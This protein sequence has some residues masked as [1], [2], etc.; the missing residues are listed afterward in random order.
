MSVKYRALLTTSLILL[1]MVVSIYLIARMV[2]LNRFAEIEA[3]TQ[4]ENLSQ[5]DKAI[6]RIYSDIDKLALDWAHWDDLHLY[7]LGQKPDFVKTNINP[8]IY[9]DLSVELIAFANQNGDIL[10]SEIYN[11]EERISHPGPPDLEPLMAKGGL[12]WGL[13]NKPGSRNRLVVTSRGTFMIN[14]QA[15][16]PTDGAPPSSGTLIFGKLVD[17]DM[18]ALL[19]METGLQINFFFPNSAPSSYQAIRPQINSAQSMYFQEDPNSDTFTGFVVLEGIDGQVAGVFQSIVQRTIY[20][21]GRL[22]LNYLLLGMIC[23]AVIGLGV[24]WLVS[25]FYIFRPMERLARRVQGSTDLK[26]Q[27]RSLSEQENSVLTEISMPLQNVLIRAQQ[28]QQESSDRQVL[29]ARLFEQAREAF[30]ILDPDSLI[31]LECNQEFASLLDCVDVLDLPQVSFRE[32]ITQH[33]S[34]NS[35]AIFEHWLDKALLEDGG[36]VEVEFERGNERRTIETSLY[37]IDV[38]DRRYLYA[39]LRDISDRRRLEQSL[40]ERLSELSL[41]NK[42]IAISTSNLDPQEIYQSVC[43]N[44]AQAFDVPQSSLALL[45]DEGGS[46]RFVAEYASQMSE[47]ILDRKVNIGGTDLARLIEN[48]QKPV[49]IDNFEGKTYLEPFAELIAKRGTKSILLIPL[50]IRDTVSGM[51]ILES[52]ERRM[53][54]QA[55]IDLAQYVSSA[56]SR[57]MEVTLLYRSLQQELLQRQQAENNLAYRE[58]FLEALVEIQNHM[59]GSTHWNEAYPA[60]LKILGE[61]T[62]ADRVYVFENTSGLNDELYTSLV[63]EW[64]AKG[65]KPEIDNPALQNMVYTGPLQRLYDH[66]SAGQP[67]S[68]ETASLTAEEQNLYLAKGVKSFLVLPLTT[69][70]AFSGLVGFDNIRSEHHWSQPE[71]ALLQVGAAALSIANERYEAINA[72]Q[73]SEDRYR[74]VFENAHDV[75]FQMDLSGRLTFLNPSWER[76]TGISL[77]ESLGLPFWKIAPPGMLQQLQT[78]FRLLRENVTDTFHQMMVMADS[79]GENVWLDAYIRLIKDGQGRATLIA[80]TLI[81]IS[82]FKR[83]EYQLRRNEESLRALYDITSSQQ[84]SFE[85][86][87]TDLLLMGNNTFRMDLGVLYHLDGEKLQVEN[88][89]PDDNLTNGSLVRISDTYVREILRANEPIGIDRVAESDWADH[90]A[91]LKSGNESILGTPVLVDNDIYGVLMFSAKAA[92]QHGFSIADKE[93][94]RLMAQWIGSEIERFRYTRR[95]Q[96]YNEEIAQKSSELAEARDQ[97]LE[98]SRLKSEFLATMSHEVRTPLNAVIGMTELLLDT[99]LNVQQDEFVHIIQ[100]SG[101]SLLGIVNDILDFSKIE[102]GRLSLESV[103]FELL[104]LVEGVVDMFLPA[105]HSKGTSILSYVAPEIP[106]YM[107]GDPARLRQVLVNL[108]GNAVKFTPRGE[109]VIRVGLIR[110][111]KDVVHLLCKV[112]D[113]GIG[114]SEVARRRLFQPFTQADGSTTRK[115]GGTGL[116]LAICKRLVEMMGG[117]IGVFSEENIGSTFWFHIQLHTPAN[118]KPAT[119]LMDEDVSLQPLR[120][121]RALVV[122]FE[123]TQRRFMAAYLKSWHIQVETARAAIEAFEKLEQ[124][125]KDGTPYHLLVWGMDEPGLNWVEVRKYLDGVSELAKVRTIF[126]SSLEQRNNLEDFLESEQS[127]A[128]YRPVKQSSLFDAIVNLFVITDPALRKNRVLPQDAPLKG[129]PDDG[130]VVLL[131]EDNPANQRLALAQLQRLGYHAEMVGNGAKAL[132]AYSLH[133]EHYSL[134]LM[135][136]QMPVMDGFEASGKIRILERWTNRHIPI[137]AMTANAMQGD[138]EACLTAGMDDY[139][140]KP[141]TIDNL[142]RVLESFL[143]I[144]DST[145]KVKVTLPESDGDEYDPLDHGVLSGLREL[146]AEGEPDFLTELIDLFLEDSAVLMMDIEHGLE[147]GDLKSIQHAAHTLKGSS[148]SLGASSFSRMC[149]EMEKAARAGEMDALRAMHTGFSQEYL[150]IREHLLRQRVV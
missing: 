60:A 78:A 79:E 114:L 132:E 126:L 136:C 149:I 65:I 120:S 42:V 85:Q 53:Y 56:A 26:E 127:A 123:P 64:V 43:A 141:V 10:F 20:Q 118:S 94:V 51:L 17:D 37:P 49:L 67:Y 35:Q 144:S 102:A 22:A 90:A 129:I 142:R 92:R 146:Q 84:V 19:Q 4:H 50:V 57:A 48:T 9:R 150:R 3:K 116:G 8:E 97:A 139:V 122:D 38:S 54:N 12:F 119:E 44:L 16:F 148:G 110:Q 147:I 93:F 106:R 88:V 25:S 34:R 70:N 1:V 74:A 29:V 63:A 15:V 135:D 55:E 130:R 66:L 133:P 111:D 117:E 143:S 115:Y 6:Q 59:L 14:A 98:A 96:L 140:S 125:R 21:E 39:V 121:L 31:V 28:V 69:R 89:Y 40:N 99:P 11:P 100:E 112:N 103:E 27:I 91:Y 138:R 30:A 76:V 46:I 95:L 105:A 47:S 77:K 23:V 24:N 33:L 107:I 145:P 71:I 62:G 101:K 73:E 5:L 32:C 61:V 109:V 87:V 72:L 137:I 7:L 80:G 81:D 124:S 2:L 131:A 58:R 52:F 18:V 45:E 86:K 75:I 128:I 36:Q 83:I 134:I 113:S 104:P 82:Q 68:A 41:L 108:V 13:E